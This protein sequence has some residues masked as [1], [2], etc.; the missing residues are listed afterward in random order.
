MV[1]SCNS[2]VVIEA[3]SYQMCRQCPLGVT[4]D[5]GWIF[6]TSHYGL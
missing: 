1:Q 2:S 5:M 6:Y 4:D 3:F